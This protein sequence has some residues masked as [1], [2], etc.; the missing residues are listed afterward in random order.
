M[1]LFLQLTLAGLAIGSVYACVAL[2]VVMIYPGH[3]S[4]QFRPRRNGDVFN[5]R[6]LGSLPSYRLHLAILSDRSRTLIHRRDHH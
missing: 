5:L 3:R 4:L 2:A 1:D 6:G